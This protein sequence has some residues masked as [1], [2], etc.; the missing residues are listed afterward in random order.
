MIGAAPHMFELI[1][2]RVTATR[3]VIAHYERNTRVR[4]MKRGETETMRKIPACCMR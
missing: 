2:L 4:P 1:S 3:V